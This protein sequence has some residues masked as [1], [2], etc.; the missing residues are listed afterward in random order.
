MCAQGWTATLLHRKE[1]GLDLIAFVEIIAAGLAAYK[2]PVLQI[3]YWLTAI[4]SRECL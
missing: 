2:A 3:I 4:K 1:I